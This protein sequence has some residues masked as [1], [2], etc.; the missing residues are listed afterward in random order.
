MRRL[1]LWTR[2]T[3]T[4]LLQ[5]LILSAIACA[6]VIVGLRAGVTAAKPFISNLAAQHVIPQDIANF[7]TQDM[8]DSIAAIDRAATCLKPADAIP[9]KPKRRVFQS[10]CYYAAAQ[11]L[12]SVL[13]RH[14]LDQDPNL[15]KIY[16]IVG[17][18]IEAL[19]TYYAAV[20]PAPGFA[21]SESV[22]GVAGEKADKELERRLKQATEEFKKLSKG[23]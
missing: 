22:D 3:A 5:L 14:H 6:P 21:G 12:R 4:L 1:P 13:N 17:G 8:D 18:A 11:D 20:N 10:K 2:I 19:E 9:E 7:A 16:L 23:N 15:G